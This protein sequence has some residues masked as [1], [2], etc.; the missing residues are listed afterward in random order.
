MISF[1]LMPSPSMLSNDLS[2]LP[3]LDVKTFSCNYLLKDSRLSTRWARLTG[4]WRRVSTYR[5]EAPIAST[6][7]PTFSELLL[8]PGPKG[9]FLGREYLIGLFILFKELVSISVGSLYFIWVNSRLSAFTHV[10]G[11]SFFGFWML[12]FSWVGSWFHSLGCELWKSVSFLQIL[13]RL[14]FN[15]CWV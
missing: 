5:W 2:C 9:I 15:F 8:L 7:C 11:H 3:I 4:G 1:V 6:I 12:S 10:L 13:R 14:L